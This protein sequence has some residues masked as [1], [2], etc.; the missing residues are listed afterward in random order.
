MEISVSNYLILIFAVLIIVAAIITIGPAAGQKSA[1]I[2]KT[3][4]NPSPSPSV[5]AG[6]YPQAP[7]LNLISGYINT[8]NKSITLS[9]YRGKVVL[10]DFWTYTCINCIRT[11]PYLNS[12]YEKYASKGLVI[13]GIHT[14]EFDFEKDYAN[15]FK[16]VQKFMIKYPIVQDNDYGTWTSYDNHYWPHV[17]L[18][19]KD[20]TIR[21]DRIGEGGDEE[22]ERNIQ[23][24]LSE[25][26]QTNQVANESLVSE[27]ISSNTDFYK[28]GTPEIYLGYSTARQP[29]GNLQGL[30]PEQSVNY[31]FPSDSAARLSPNLVYLEGTWKINGDHSELISNEGKIAL[32]YK[33]RSVNIVAGGGPSDLIITLDDKN[34]DQTNIGTDAIF[35]GNE[36]IAHINGLRL[37]NAVNDSGYNQRTVILNIKGKGFRIYTFTFG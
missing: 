10:L 14:P 17:Y 29:I 18:I 30:P 11:I 1:I 25:L 9:Q 15:V 32:N 6:S 26:D 36:A 22:I 21:Y 34:E 35:V 27:N 7:E 23:K 2:S 3:I 33:A 28:I 37:Y 12:W 13:I 8:N 20:G 4:P 16:A 5:S 24:L 19:D 31:S